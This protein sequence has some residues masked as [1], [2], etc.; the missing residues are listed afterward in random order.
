MMPPGRRLSPG[1]APIPSGQQGYPEA[2]ED[3]S[4]QAKRKQCNEEVHAAVE[5]ARQMREDGEKRME[6]QQRR[7]DKQRSFDDYK[8]DVENERPRSRTTSESSADRDR[9][10]V[11]EKVIFV[12]F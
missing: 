3:E 9:H 7:G 1:T 6:E 11:R 8:E 4:I 2:D 5:R 12:S 10:H